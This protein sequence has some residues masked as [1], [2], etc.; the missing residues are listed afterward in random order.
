[1]PNIAFMSLVGRVHYEYLDDGI[2]SSNKGIYGP[3]FIGSAFKMVYQGEDRYGGSGWNVLYL[4]V[5]DSHD[6]DNDFGYTVRIWIVNDGKVLPLEA[7]KTENMLD[8]P[9]DEEEP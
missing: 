1:M 7:R 5:N 3:G 6:N 8:E 2:D 9:D 4:A